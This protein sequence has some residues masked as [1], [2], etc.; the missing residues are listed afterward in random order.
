MAFWRSVR[1]NEAENA[2][3]PWR[4]RKTRPRLDYFSIRIAYRTR[5]TYSKAAEVRSL[6]PGIVAAESRPTCPLTFQPKG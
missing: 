3:R 4:V 5:R 2:A 1:G 6:T